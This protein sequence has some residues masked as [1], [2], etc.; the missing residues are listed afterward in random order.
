MFRILILTSSFFSAVRDWRE[1]TIDKAKFVSS[2]CVPRS[3]FN[4]SSST[5]LA[6]TFDLLLLFFFRH[7]IGVEEE[8]KDSLTSSSSSS[9]SSG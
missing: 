6:V 1:G 5:S 2:S 7:T 3:A 4:S 8:V 9:S